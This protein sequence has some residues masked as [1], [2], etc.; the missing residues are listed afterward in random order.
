MI[1]EIQFIPS[2]YTDQDSCSLDSL[3]KIRNTRVAPSVTST[4]LIS[5]TLQ[6]SLSEEPIDVSLILLSL[7]KS[8]YLANKGSDL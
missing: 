3:Y 7:S 8:C 5:G 1:R 4:R 6:I 2:I